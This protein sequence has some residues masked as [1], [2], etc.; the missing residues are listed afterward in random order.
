MA[1]P[2]LL[3]YNLDPDTQARLEALCNR[4]GIRVRRVKPW[5]YGQSIGALAGIPAGAGAA[6]TAGFSEA[7][8]V[9]CHMLGP[10]LDAFLTGMRKDGIPRIALKA[11]LTPSNIA[12]NSVQLHA[13]LAREHEAVNKRV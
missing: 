10:Q 13:E 1:Q 6:P 9:M 2:L 8:L 3:T 7:M 11:I 5:E 12:W 4:Q